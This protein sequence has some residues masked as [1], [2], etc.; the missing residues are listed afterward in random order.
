MRYFF[1]ILLLLTNIL[2]AETHLIQKGYPSRSNMNTRCNGG[3]WSTNILPDSYF[4]LDM[5][6]SANIITQFGVTQILP[7]FSFNESTNISTL[8]SIDGFSVRLFINVI[9]NDYEEYVIQYRPCY[10]MIHTWGKV[11]YE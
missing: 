8:T 2:K 5:S 7:N 3:S 10:I 4:I 11:I 1:M 6:A 9:T